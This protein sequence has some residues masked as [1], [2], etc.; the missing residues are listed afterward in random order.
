VVAIYREK[1]QTLVWVVPVDGG[2]PRMI[3][4]EDRPL[5]VDDVIYAAADAP[6]LIESFAL[7]SLDACVP[8][9]IRGSSGFPDLTLEHG[10]VAV[11][12]DDDAS[13]ANDILR[14]P[15]VDQRGFAEL[16]VDAIVSALGNPSADSTDLEVLIFSVAQRFLCP[17]RAP[18]ELYSSSW[19]GPGL[20]WLGVYWAEHRG[21]RFVELLAELAAPAGEVERGWQA[22]WSLVDGLH[23]LAAQHVRRRA[24]ALLEV[25]QTGQLPEGQYCHFWSDLDKLDRGRWRPAFARAVDALAAT[26]PVSLSKR[27]S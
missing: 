6:G 4:V 25:S 27:E 21:A 11:Y 10:Q 20:D 19:H 17:P 2:T 13:M 22:E 12:L 9:P 3:D 15:T 1:H 7:P 18:R 5:L 23:H 26:G 8:L 14:P 16:S 24:A